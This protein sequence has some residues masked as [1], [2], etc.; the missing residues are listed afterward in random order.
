MREFVGHKAVRVACLG[1]A[2]SLLLAACGEPEQQ[3][4]GAVPTDQNQAMTE[5]EPAP[6]EPTEQQ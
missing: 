1:G 5:Q 2:L 6:A 3:Q 4:Q